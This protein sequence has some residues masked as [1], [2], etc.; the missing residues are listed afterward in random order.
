MGVAEDMDMMMTTMMMM[1]MTMDMGGCRG[2][3]MV[4]SPTDPPSPGRV[5]R[6][7]TKRCKSTALSAYGKMSMPWCCTSDTRLLSRCDVWQRSLERNTKL[8]CFIW[9]IL[10][11]GGKSFGELGEMTKLHTFSLP[12]L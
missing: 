2:L 10:R 5:V 4:C 8:V 6:A 12:R 7:T 9:M 3:D 11:G 1:M